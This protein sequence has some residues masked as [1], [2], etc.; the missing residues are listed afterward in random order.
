MPIGNSPEPPEY[1]KE[2]EMEMREMQKVYE[3]WDNLSEEEQYNLI[4]DW[5]PNDFT[6]DDDA[7]SFFGD[8]PNDKQLWIWQRENNITEENIQGQKDIAGDFEYEERKLEGDD[9]E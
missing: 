3:W 5:Y 8:M 1:D 6:E 7:D 4:L 9:I 2:K